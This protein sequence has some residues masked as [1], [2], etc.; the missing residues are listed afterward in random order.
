M[1][2]LRTLGVALIAAVVGVASAFVVVFVVY[3]DSRPDLLMWHET[4]LKSEYTAAS[5]IHTFEEYVALE[6]RVFAELDERIYTRSNTGDTRVIN[7]YIRGSISDPARWAQNW[8]RTFELRQDAPRA[9]VLLLHGMS[10]SPYSLRALGQRLHAEGAWV[11]GLR[12]PG[13][14]TLPSGL[15][16]L[17][18]QDMAAATRLA[19]R[20]LHEKTAGA[21]LFIIGYSTGGALAVEYTLDGMNDGNLPQPAGLI[22]ISPAIGVT[23][24]AVL[25]V[26]Q[27]RLGRLLG[28]DKL[29]WSDLKP[30][31]DP[32]KYGS[33]AVN[34]GDQVYRLTV[35][36]ADRLESMR[37]ANAL[38]RFPRVLVFQSAVDATVS[39]TA[40]TTILLR[41]LPA[42]RNELILFD[43]NRIVEVEALL[44]ADP[45]PSIDALI[46]DTALPFTVSVVTNENTQSRSVV[47][48]RSRAGVVDIRAL[49]GANSWPKGV[50]CL[51]HVALPIAPVDSLYGAEPSEPSPGIQLGSLAVYGER[52]AAQ[53]PAADMLRLR[54]NPFY[55]F[56]EGKVLEFV[57][58][59]AEDSNA[60]TRAAVWR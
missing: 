46:R 50:F 40:V 55:A 22:L 5:P 54:W 7:R 34:A 51:S 41:K 1:K 20:H 24:A 39:V 15:T 17:R 56:V 49:P 2:I 8:N 45:A 23:P 32:F 53:V 25:A 44:R 28:L 6:S 42:G 30:E 57:L 58:P 29:A 21:P 26:W 52:D 47:L 33:F 48:K 18:W 10:D 4:Q 11:V 3:L 13:H 14:G 38:L 16:T 27:A 60:L 31:Y 12:L 43:V 37:K 36:V 9:A 35:E 59:P 19:V